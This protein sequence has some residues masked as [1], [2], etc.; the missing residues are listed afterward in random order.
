MA[1]EYNNVFPS[2]SGG[3]GARTGSVNVAGTG[4][5]CAGT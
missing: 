2:L 3:N 5:H 4:V 1:C